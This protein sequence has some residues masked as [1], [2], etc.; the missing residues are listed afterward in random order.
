M[1]PFMPGDPNETR[2]LRKGVVNSLVESLEQ[3]LLTTEEETFG[4][5]PLAKGIQA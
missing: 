1:Y 5:E 4:T 3:L 2:Q